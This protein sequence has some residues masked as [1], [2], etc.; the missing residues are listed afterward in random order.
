MIEKEIDGITYY[1]FEP[2]EE[3]ARNRFERAMIGDEVIAAL[4]K[5][6]LDTIAELESRKR[7][8]WRDVR[9]DYSSLSQ[10][11]ENTDIAYDSNLQGFSVVEKK[12]K[13]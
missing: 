4:T 3:E 13:R 9:R 5:A 12:P 11:P 7:E 10:I 8:A 1:C 6:Y 2:S